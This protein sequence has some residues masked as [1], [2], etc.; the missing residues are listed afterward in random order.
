MKVVALYSDKGGVSKTTTAPNLAASLKNAYPNSRV[1][2]MDLCSD[3]GHLSKRYA[4]DKENALEGAWAIVEALIDPRRRR[5]E[6]S[7][8]KAVQSATTSLRVVPETS[9]AEGCIQFINVG[10]GLSHNLRGAR[11]FGSADD[12]RRFGEEF[13][14][15]IERVLG[16]DFLVVDLPGMV[17]EAMVRSVLPHCYAVVIPM[18]VRSYMN[19][20]EAEVLVQKLRSIDVDVSGYLR[21]FVEDGDAAPKSQEAADAVLTELSMSTGVPILEGGIPNRATLRQS[22]EPEPDPDG[23]PSQVGLYTMA[24]RA[25]LNGSQRGVIQRTITAVEGAVSAML[26]EADAL[27]TAK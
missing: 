8:E 13:M 24:A 5:E 18:D 22:I 16:L 19:M 17:D 9:G 15:A 11:V 26:A 3:H 6:G 21:T 12:A 20:A 4:I 27:A 10:V 14:D 7:A 23:G 2:L 1:G 25:G